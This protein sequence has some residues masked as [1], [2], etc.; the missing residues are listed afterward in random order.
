MKY[1]FDEIIER[2]GTN[3]F[4]WDSLEL[5]KEWG[6]TDH[7]NKNTISLFTADMD[8][9][10]APA[11]EA[12]M[13]K[14]VD[15]RIYGY[16][17]PSQDYYD[18]IINWF[19]R[20]HDWDIKKEEIIYSPGTVFALGIAIRAYS[21][22][23]DGVII[24]RPVYAPFTGQ[25]EG[26]NR[27][28]VNN[29]MLLD[30][31]GN[32][33][34]NLKEFEELAKKDENKMFILCNPHNPSGR[35]F[36]N[37]ELKIMAEICAKNNVVIIADE[38]HGDLIRKDS[39]FTPIVKTTDKTDHI[40]TCTAINKTFNVAGLHA[41]NIVIQNK[42]L[43]D[44]FQKTLGFAMPTPFTINAVIAAY[45]ECD[46]WL[47]EINTYFDGTID[48]LMNF[49]KE[50]MP[51]VKFVRPE[52]TYIFWMDF[53]AYNISAADIKKRIYV[54]ANVVLESGSMFD[55][56]KGDGFERVCLSSPRPLIKEA[57]ERIVK[58]FEDIN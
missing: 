42:E 58:A 52:G 53:R 36:S 7:F 47:D 33:S 10:V 29:Q 16:S 48:W 15:N 11:I 43:R 23:G 20:K 56:E 6:I 19:K 49:L 31:E 45:N 40:V 21:K 28:V 39:I 35:I 46:E 34:I 2:R 22:E 9:A 14:T 32:Y 26:H 57:F 17:F 25:I 13:H 12:A 27:V 8:I 5:L 41:S 37:E 18:S 54:D 38:I 51:K 3:S 24:Q 4:K 44:K 1:N 50:K 30:E 55:P